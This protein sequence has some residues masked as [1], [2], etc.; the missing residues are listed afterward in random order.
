MFLYKIMC[1]HLILG[2]T[3][4]K[5]NEVGLIVINNFYINNQFWMFYIVFNVQKY[6]V[7]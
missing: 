5:S 1:I 6:I 3:C 4:T 2:V 7:D